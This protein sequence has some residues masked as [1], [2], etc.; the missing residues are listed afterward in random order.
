M[1][2]QE[3]VCFVGVIGSGKDYR[4]QQ[5][6]AKG[7]A[8]LDFKDALID[9]VI[10]LVGFDI[11]PVYE[12]F[13]ASVIGTVTPDMG[14]WRRKTG[15]IV[16]RILLFFF[17]QLMTGRKVLLRLGTEVMR[18]RD[19]DYWLTMFTISAGKLLKEGKSIACADCRFPNEVA[20]VIMLGHI[21]RVKTRFVF[22]DYHSFR[23]NKYVQHESE[24]LAQELVSKGVSDGQELMF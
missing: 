12:D 11:R 2:T 21:L 5:L 6:V 4:K 18:K 15:V 23:Y 10:D 14:P 1:N 19:K 24:K 3:I 20:G 13:K 7:Y 9:M 22:C 16:S 17:P 8:P